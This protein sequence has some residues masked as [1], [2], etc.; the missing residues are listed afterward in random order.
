MSGTAAPFGY[1]ETALSTRFYYIEMICTS[2][3]VGT[4]KRE[5]GRNDSGRKLSG[6]AP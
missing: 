2:V 3:F 1:E 4:V 6:F 5:L